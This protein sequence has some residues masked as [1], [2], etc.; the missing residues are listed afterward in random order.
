[1]VPREL[2]PTAA[3]IAG[4]I[5][6]RHPPRGATFL[7]CKGSDSFL[8]WG[9]VRGMKNYSNSILR[10]FVVVYWWDRVICSREMSHKA[11]DKA[12]CNL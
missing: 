7:G 10:E 2:S 4:V 6:E 3:T 12:Q 9:V 5:G 1:M 11:L 8:C